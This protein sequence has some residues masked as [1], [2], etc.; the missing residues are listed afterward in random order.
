M[1]YKPENVKTKL[2]SSDWISG[3]LPVHGFPL[4]AERVRDKFVLV[5]KGAK[6]DAFEVMRTGGRAHKR[7]VVLRH[8]DGREWRLTGWHSRCGGYSGCR[9]IA[10]R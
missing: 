5:G 4:H 3:E 2:H 9:V 1:N 6:L 8:D 10:I 7:W